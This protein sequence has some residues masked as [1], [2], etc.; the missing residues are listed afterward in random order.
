MAT[1][2]A[3]GAPSLRLATIVNMRSNIENLQDRP[4]K[5]TRQL[6]R[7]SGFSITD[8]RGAIAIMCGSVT[9]MGNDVLSNLKY[10]STALIDFRI[11]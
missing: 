11:I 4:A 10:Y 9:L 7:N 2:T 3:W 5:V 1:G 8:I 6:L